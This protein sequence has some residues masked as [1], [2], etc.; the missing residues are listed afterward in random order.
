MSAT[1]LIGDFTPDCPAV[2][3][4]VEPGDLTELELTRLASLTLLGLSDLN[5]LLK[6]IHAG[7][8]EGVLISLAKI[9]GVIWGW[10]A[11]DTWRH[12]VC[13]NCFVEECWREQGIG[14]ALVR[15]LVPR[16]KAA[17]QCRPH[18]DTSALEFYE[19][20]VPELFQLPRAKRAT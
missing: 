15:A 17:Y 2:I 4:V 3:S 13:M 12:F 8:V 18:V 20:A 14:T 19:R 9:E 7:D 6:D 1:Q 16:Y 11:I 5:L 10:A